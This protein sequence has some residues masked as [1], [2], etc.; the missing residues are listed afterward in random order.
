[1]ETQFG[2]P[3]S[4]GI[5]TGH[6]VSATTEIRENLSDDSAAENDKECNLS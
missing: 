6:K 5:L 1:M 4:I 3:I 2:D